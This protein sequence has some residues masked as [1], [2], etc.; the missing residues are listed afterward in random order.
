MTVQSLTIDV[1]KLKCIVRLADM[2][3]CGAAVGMLMEGVTG[4]Q[5]RLA[6]QALLLVQPAFT[7]RGVQFQPEGQEMLKVCCLSVCLSR[8][9][10]WYTAKLLV[11]IVPKGVVFGYH[12]FLCLIVSLCL[13]HIRHLRE[14]ACSPMTEYNRRANPCW[15]LDVGL[16]PKPCKSSCWQT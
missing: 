6:S 14:A 12:S 3:L 10:A 11:N 8:W 1:A 7:P 16:L 13:G 9:A 4:L 15:S 2:M 5:A